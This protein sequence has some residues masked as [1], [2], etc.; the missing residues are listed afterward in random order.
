MASCILAR[1]STGCSKDLVPIANFVE[2]RRWLRLT[3]P[4]AGGSDFGSFT[5]RST[6]RVGVAGSDGAGALIRD[7]ESRWLLPHRIQYSVRGTSSTAVASKPSCHREGQ[8]PF[9]ARKTYAPRGAVQPQRITFFPAGKPA[10]RG[11]CASKRPPLSF[12]VGVLRCA[13]A[14]KRFPARPFGS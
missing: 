9:L 3:L 13:A 12:S 5:D 8:S 1:A 2:R 14:G 10:P 4:E 6:V 7:V 11:R